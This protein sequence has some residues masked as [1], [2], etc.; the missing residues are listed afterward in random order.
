VLAGSQAT[1]TA[2][3][4]AVLGSATGLVPAVALVEARAHSFVESAAGG[5]SGFLGQGSRVHATSYL[6]V[7]WWF[8]AAT[9]VAV[10]V[11]AGLGAA[12]VTRSRVAPRRRA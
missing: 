2:A 1:V 12:A 6:A 9:I 10:P 3:L 11:L 8:L 7:P 4:G 5:G